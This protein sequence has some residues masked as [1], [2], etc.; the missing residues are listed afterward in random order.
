MQNLEKENTMSWYKIV[1]SPRMISNGQLGQI[2]DRF[3][4]IKTARNTPDTFNAFISKRSEGH[5]VTLYFNPDAAYYAES[6]I[7][8]N[9]AQEC[10][11]PEIEEL[12]STLLGRRVTADLLVDD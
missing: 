5:G 11:R 6:L 8:R 3:A 9:G 10:E 12:A 4:A 2:T 1:L 7:R